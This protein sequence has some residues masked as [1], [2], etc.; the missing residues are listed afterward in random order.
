MSALN[1]AFYLRHFSTN[2]YYKDFE[3]TPQLKEATL[4]TIEEVH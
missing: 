3:L 4:L 1:N 2:L